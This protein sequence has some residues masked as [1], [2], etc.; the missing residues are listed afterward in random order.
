[1]GIFMYLINVFCGG[2]GFGVRVM[3]AL[4]NELGSTYPSSVSS[5]CLCRIVINLSSCIFHFR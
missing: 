4:E 3:L 1:M 2:P 5:K